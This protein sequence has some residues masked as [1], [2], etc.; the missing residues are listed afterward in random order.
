MRKAKVVGEFN[1]EDG[2][3]I[4]LRPLSMRDIDESLL[5]AN[6]LVQERRNSP[7]MG[8]VSFAKRVTRKEEARFLRTVV[9]GTSEREFVNVAAFVGEKLVGMCDVRRRKAKDE[10]HSA[11]LGIVILE[12]YRGV[13]IGERMMGEALRQARAL[14]IW[15]VELTVFAINHAAIHLYEKMGFR[16][17]GTIPEKIVRGERHFDE[18]TMYV[19][20]RGSDISTKGPRRKS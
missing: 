18:V 14:G 11:V 8:V 9:R 13:G 3:R 16:R 15:L 6:T 4:V 19:D 10:H 7:E 17:V 1:T 2:R 5:F 20:L 12:G